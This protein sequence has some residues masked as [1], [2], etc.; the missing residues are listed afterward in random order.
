[1]AGRRQAPTWWQVVTACPC[2][3][4]ATV[5]VQAGDRCDECRPREYGQHDPRSAPSMMNVTLGSYP[6][7]SNAG[8][9]GP[10]REF[11]A[12]VP[13]PIQRQMAA[14]NALAHEAGRVLEVYP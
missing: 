9:Y 5:R 13:E 4:K 7:S 6:R 10:Y 2:G 1:M 8:K 14:R 11:T 12:P 3:A